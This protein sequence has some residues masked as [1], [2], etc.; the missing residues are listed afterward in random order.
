MRRTGIAIAA[1][2]ALVSVTVMA[3]P[4]AVAAAGERDGLR[5]PVAAERPPGGTLVI[6]LTG[7]LPAVEATLKVRGYRGAADGYRATVTGTE[8]RKLTGLDN[9]WYSITARDKSGGGVVARPGKPSRSVHLTRTSGAVR[10][11]RYEQ[12]APAGALRFTQISAGYGHTCA[13]STAHAAWCWGADYTYQLGDGLARQAWHPVRVLGGNNY[14][15][16]AADYSSSCGLLTSGAPM[17]WGTDGGDDRYRL[18]SGPDKPAAVPDAVGP[19]TQISGRCGLDMSGA[20]WC[21]PLP[22]L[23]WGSPV[24]HDNPPAVRVPGGHVYTQ[25]S[26]GCGMEASG[27]AWCRRSG[28]DSPPTAIGGARFKRISANEYRVCGVTRSNRAWCDGAFVKG[29]HRFRQVTAG[30]QH[31]CGIDTDGAT[32]CWGSNRG[33]GQ[34]GTGDASATTSRKPLLVAGEHRFVQLTGGYNFTCGIDTRG[35]AW[36]WGN[37]RDGQV[38]DDTRSNRLSP[39]AVVGP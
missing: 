12:A 27:T 29:K 15:Q 38:G 26:F 37:N 21:W 5:Q 7:A 23:P 14:R 1:S 4:A 34:L 20:A 17:C 3:S 10:T 28:S 35:H 8:R 6:R 25:I 22:D 11:F 39:V 31:A 19:F 30:N 2:L 32:W 16:V 36:C 13:V 24:T 9:G 33:P 18:P